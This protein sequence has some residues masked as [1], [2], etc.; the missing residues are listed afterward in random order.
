[1]EL[2]HPLSSRTE[3]KFA[4]YYKT[5]HGLVTT[6]SSLSSLYED[7]GEEVRSLA[8]APEVRSYSLASFDELPNYLNQGMAAYVGGAEVFLRHRIPDKFFG[9]ISYAYT[10]A[11]RREHIPRMP[12]IVRIFLITHTSLASSPTTLS[13]PISR[14]AGSGSI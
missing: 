7:T 12:P 14:S 2:E 1:M 4:T 5:S 8:L 3:L 6:K 13:T 10:H 11:E 9:W